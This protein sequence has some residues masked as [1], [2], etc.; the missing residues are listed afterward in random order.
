MYI[1]IYFFV[2]GRK[3]AGGGRWRRSAGKEAEEEKD[4][5]R[6]ATSILSI[7]LQTLPNAI[8]PGKGGASPCAPWRVARHLYTYMYNFM[9]CCVFM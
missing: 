6:Q 4:R 8:A 3:T 7:P 2:F 9:F 5:R 1:Y